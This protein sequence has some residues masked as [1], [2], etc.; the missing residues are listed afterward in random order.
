MNWNDGSEDYN[1]IARLKRDLKAL[2]SY[3]IQHRADCDF[4]RCA[5][6]ESSFLGCRVA[7]TCES[8][9]RRACS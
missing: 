9:T 5:T 4:H 8:P 7:G 3:A 6:C 1:I 2:G